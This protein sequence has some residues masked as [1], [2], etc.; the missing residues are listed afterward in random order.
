VPTEI[1]VTGTRGLDR[2]L[3]GIQRALNR[4]M[5]AAS[6]VAASLLEAGVREKLPSGI[7]HESVFSNVTTVETLV[8]GQ[9][10][11]R[12]PLG[13]F[14]TRTQIPNL[15]VEIG[16]R[17]VGRDGRA[18]W[19]QGGTGR[20]ADP[21]QRGIHTGYPVSAKHLREDGKPG[22]L[23]FV[24][25]LRTRAYRAHVFI[26]GTKPKHVLESTALELEPEIERIYEAA[27][28]AAVREG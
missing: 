7:P 28:D 18:V 6:H 22:V 19:V 12:D 27:F 16:V 25:G 11:Q 2:R 8:T 3:N 24:G 5:R 20:F 10:V 23:S 26:P 21:V 13:R 15:L 1:V 4:N 17:E 9:T 14:A